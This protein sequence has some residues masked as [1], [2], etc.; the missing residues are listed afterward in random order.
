MLFLTFEPPVLT[1]PAVLPML[2]PNRTWARRGK[3]DA[4][5]PEAVIRVQAPWL[6]AARERRVLILSKYTARQVYNAAATR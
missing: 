3:I 2:P 1:S 6:R 4:I 5:D